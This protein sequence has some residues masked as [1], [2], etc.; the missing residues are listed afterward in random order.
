MRW[1]LSIFF[2]FL[3]T[4][5][6]AALLFYPPDRKRDAEQFT[7]PTDQTGPPVINPPHQFANEEKR[8]AQVERE[9]ARPPEPAAPAPPEAAPR[10]PLRP[11][12]NDPDGKAVLTLDWEDMIPPDWRPDLF[13][14]DYDIDQLDDDD[15][16]A[17]ELLDKLQ[18]VWAAAPV[19]A[20]LDGRQVRL[21][22][23]AVP[24]DAEPGRVSEFLLVPYFGACIHVPPPPANQIVY[25][26]ASR[27]GELFELDLFD[28]VWVQGTMQTA[29]FSAEL[30]EAGYTIMADKVEPYQD[31]SV[32]VLE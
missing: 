8:T 28:T 4:I 1:T 22:G 19:V 27:P 26:K 17:I 29:N 32:I 6:L 21:P 7:S 14:Q 23:F 5:V 16:L 15:D 11:D 13:F 2:A 20:E 31:D 24:L 25:V 30:G 3:L 10:P 9:T 18:E 12:F